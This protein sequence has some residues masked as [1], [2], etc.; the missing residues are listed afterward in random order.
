MEYLNQEGIGTG[1]H[2]PIPIYKQKL[3]QEMG[4]TDNCPE[5]EKAASEVLSLPVHPGLTIEEL[6]K[7]AISLE[8]ASEN[9]L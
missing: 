1:I 8:A 6:E 9:I 5:T 2:Y 3:Y 7:I 4:Y